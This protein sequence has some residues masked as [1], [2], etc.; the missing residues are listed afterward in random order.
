MCV[1]ATRT[2][3]TECADGAAIRQGDQA[4]AHNRSH[5]RT[6]QGV[7]ID[8]DDITRGKKLGHTGTAEGLLPRFRGFAPAAEQG[9]CVKRNKHDFILCTGQR[10]ELRGKRDSWLSRQTAQLSRF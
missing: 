7:A 1:C 3:E 6:P 5:R 4:M 2:T 9:F 8:M 10:P